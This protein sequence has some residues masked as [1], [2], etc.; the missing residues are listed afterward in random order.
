M[1]S[2]IVKAIAPSSAGGT[3][4]AESPSE[5]E[6]SAVA[7]YKEMI[8][9]QDDQIQHLRQRLA[10]LDAQYITAQVKQLFYFRYVIVILIFLFI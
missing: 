1:E 9:E 4:G 5:A 7:K 2:Q 10:A 6:L 3:K 8:R